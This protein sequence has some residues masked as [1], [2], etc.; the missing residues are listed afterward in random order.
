VWLHLEVRRAGSPPKDSLDRRHQLDPR[1]GLVEHRHDAERLEVEPVLLLEAPA[2][3]DDAGPRQQLAGFVGE[4]S[5]S[6]FRL[7]GLT[8]DEAVA[9]LA[10]LG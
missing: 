8:L 6:G 2:G 9:V 5:P 3:D 4:V 7:E 1:E 10:R